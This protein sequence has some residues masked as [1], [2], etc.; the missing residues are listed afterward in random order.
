[1]SSEYKVQRTGLG[2]PLK[3]QNY[4]TL[5]TFLN[6]ELETLNSVLTG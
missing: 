5:I 1:M 6:S 3:A 2:Q 4:V